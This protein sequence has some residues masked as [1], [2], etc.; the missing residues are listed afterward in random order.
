MAYCTAQDLI[1]LRMASERE[2]IQLSDE[3]G[4][5]TLDTA[6]ITAAAEQAALEIDAYLSA[7]VVVP[8]ASPSDGIKRLAAILTYFHLFPEPTE[9]A[10]DQYQRALVEL[11]AIASGA[12]PIDATGA[13]VATHWPDALEWADGPGRIF[14]RPDSGGLR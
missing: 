12:L 11:G 7:Q 1:D 4:E 2:L 6:V 10:S 5:G 9:H 3:A 8:L 13:R 14:R